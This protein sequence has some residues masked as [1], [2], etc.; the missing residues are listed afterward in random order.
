[1]GNPKMP[2]IIRTAYAQGKYDMALELIERLNRG[3]HP[4][5]VLN[6]AK[7]VLRDTRP[8]VMIVEGQRELDLGVES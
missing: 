1:M 6:W 2:E 5:H 8:L 4:A 3:D 7:K